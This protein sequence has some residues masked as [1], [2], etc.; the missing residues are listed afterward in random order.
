MAAML[1]RKENADPANPT[2]WLLPYTNNNLNYTRFT[3]VICD[4]DGQGRLCYTL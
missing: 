4:I 3:T 1:L 2:K